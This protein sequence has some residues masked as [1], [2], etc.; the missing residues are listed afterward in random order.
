M[1]FSIE[2]DTEH[3]PVRRSVRELVHIIERARHD[4]TNRAM[5]CDRALKELR[6]RRNEVESEIKQLMDIRDMIDARVD[7]AKTGLPLKEI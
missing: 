1:T 5:A 7:A 2:Q 4:I 6:T 3:R